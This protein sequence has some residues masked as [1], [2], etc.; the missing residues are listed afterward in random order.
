EPVRIPRDSEAL[1]LLQQVR[2]E[3]H[4]FAITYHRQLRQK[5]MT[6]SV[7]DEVPGL[8]PTRRSR[9]LKEFGSVKKLRERSLDEL[10]ALTWLPDRVARDL[11]ERL[12][13]GAATMDSGHG[14]AVD[15]RPPRRHRYVRC[16]PLCRRRRAGGPRVLRDRQPAAGTDPEGRR[17]RAGP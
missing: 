5:K 9:L 13:G 17:A 3:A 10:T 11:Y 12:H 2:D 15:P 4:R 16:G 14:S 6:K 7:L 1:Y 8:G